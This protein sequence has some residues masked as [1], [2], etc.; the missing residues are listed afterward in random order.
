MRTSET[1]KCVVTAMT[2]MKEG[3]HGGAK[4][5]SDIYMADALR[6]NVAFICTIVRVS[7]RC[8]YPTYLTSGRIGY[9][10]G[11]EPPFSASELKCRVEGIYGVYTCLPYAS[12]G[13]VRSYCNEASQG[14]IHEPN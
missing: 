4:M 10:H 11:S 5:W 3:S 7:R 6:L 12:M 14:G 1:S 2:I 8:A 9:C 13:A